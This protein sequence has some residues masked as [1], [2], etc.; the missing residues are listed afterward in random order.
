MP[1]VSTSKLGAFNIRVCAARRI[2]RHGGRCASRGEA[3]G[4]RPREG[5]HDSMESGRVA[6]PKA[7]AGERGT[8]SRSTGGKECAGICALFARPGRYGRLRAVSPA[9][10]GID[11][12][13]VTCKEGGAGKGV[14]ETPSRANWQ[15]LGRVGA[16]R[17]KQ[18][19]P[20]K[21]ACKRG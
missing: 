4:S 5:E 16:V 14:D 1:R 12:P 21:P 3:S 9:R 10:S 17:R 6:V 18:I 8:I 11:G 15:D 13:S 20:D 2:Q 19:A 7:D